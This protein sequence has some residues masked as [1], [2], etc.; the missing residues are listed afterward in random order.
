MASLYN[1]PD[2]F[3]DS[4]DDLVEIGSRAKTAVATEVLFFEDDF[5]DD[6]DLDL[7]YQEPTKLPPP[8]PTI[9][10]KPSN[11]IDETT[12]PFS[13]RS[14]NIVPWSSSPP[15]HMLPSHPLLTRT[16]SSTRT[17]KR[18]SLGETELPPPKKRS[19]PRTWTAQPR[20][21]SK[22]GLHGESTPARKTKDQMPWNTTA[23]AVKAQKK[24]HKDTLKRSGTNE[25]YTTE[26]MRAVT[27]MDSER[28]KG[29]SLSKEQERV[30]DLVVNKGESVFFTGPA[31]T[32]KSVLMRSIVAELRKKFAKDPER[33]AVTASTGLAACNIGGQTL[34]SFSGIG[35]GKEE[36]P[37]LVKK[38]RR[39]AKAKNRWLRTKTRLRISLARLKRYDAHE[40]GDPQLREKLLANVMAPKSIE[41]K[42]GAQVML[43]KNMDETLVNGSL[44]RVRGFMTESMFEL[45][46][47]TAFGT[48]DEGAPDARV[49][50]RI[51]AFTREL[52]ESRTGATEYPVVEFSASD[53]THRTI[54]CIGEEYKVENAA[55]EVQACRRQI[56]LILA[57]ALSIHKAQG[58]TLERVKVD[59]GKVFEKG[60]AY[61]AL[62]RA[63]RQQGLQV[64]R[65]EKHKVMAHPRVVNFY[66]NLYSIDEAM[67]KKP[68]VTVASI[69]S[70]PKA[71]EVASR[72]TFQTNTR[73]T[74]QKPI[75][76]AVGSARAPITLDDDDDDEDAMAEA[77]GH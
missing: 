26:E 61:V 3:Q 71:K 12:V 76:R 29:I 37:V 11:E 21:D 39:N 75:P 38:I 7:D 19:L 73:P 50:N 44:G 18:S 57:W 68:A 5:S 1:Q 41:L 10:Q 74:V 53:G 59:L 13:S 25:G 77:Y 72:S 48:D 15:S 58:Q 43:V 60:Q 30:Q 56:P 23:S 66:N 35:L 62:S 65:F 67:A 20:D 63:T 47:D 70:A 33:L 36:V 17:S 34:H 14:E 45:K 55:G 40:T 24:H 28:V 52:E 6:T 42:V 27:A 22:L 49:Q 4:P 31:G 32:G 69:F 2:S 8:P 9:S 64:L 51:K 46:N 54:L 16:V